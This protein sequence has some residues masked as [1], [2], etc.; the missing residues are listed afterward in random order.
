MKPLSRAVESM[1]RSGIRV[2][3]DRAFS[4]PDCIRLEVG[5]PNFPT[6]SH[7]LEAADKAAREGK[8]RYTENPGIPELRSRIAEIF[9]ADTGRTTKTDDVVVTTG[10]MAALYTTLMSITDPGDEVIVMSPSWPNYLMQMT[11]LGIRPI[12]VPTTEATGHVP[13]VE[14]LESAVSHRTKAVL[15]NSPC[16]PTGAVINQAQMADILEFARRA[17]IY[18]ISDEVYD[19]I[20]YEGTHVSAASHDGDG[21]VVCIHSFSK[22]YSMTGWRVGYAVAPPEIAGLIRKCQEPT[23]SCVNAPAQYAALAALDGPQEIIGEMRDAYRERRDEARRILSSSG[24]PA[25]EPGG[26]FYI[27]IDVSSSG[28]SDVAFAMDLVDKHQVAVV[29]G[30]TFGPGNENRVRVSLATAPDLLY[31]GMRRLI[32][33]TRS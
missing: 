23:V 15:I 16:N 9:A 2:I 8:T 7:V 31:E 25:L 6:P 20:I 30:S 22:T 12:V 18:V 3:M 4:M 33:E 5:E 11:L 29:P 28:R 32:D 21:R 14:Q 26:A 17:D 10:A 27:W 19:K 24:I 13:T 1:P